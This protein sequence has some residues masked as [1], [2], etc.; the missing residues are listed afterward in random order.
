GLWAQWRLEETGG[1]QRAPGE[2]VLLSCRGSGFKDENHVIWWYRQAPGGSPDWVSIDSSDSSR[3]K[4]GPA[5]E[6]RA[7]MFRDKSRSEAH[8]SLRAL[9]PRD[10]A[11]YF[12][13]ALTA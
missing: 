2:F 3:D 11:R 5:I 4:Y 12:C 9:Q 1:E 10:S 13:A 8:L 6:S 7:L